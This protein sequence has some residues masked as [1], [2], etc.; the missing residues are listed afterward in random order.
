MGLEPIVIRGADVGGVAGLALGVLHVAA[1]FVFV[2]GN[3]Q[4]ATTL[5]FPVAYECA[6]GVDIAELLSGHPKVETALIAAAK[7][8]EQRGARA[9]VGACGSFANF[10][11]ALT[12]A[13][14]IPVFSSV[15]TQIP[16]LL[17]GL[18]KAQRLAVIFA[19]QH[20]FTA[21][22]RKECGILDDKR[23]VIVDCM[24]IS[25]FRALVEE[26]YQIR[27][28]ELRQAVTDLARQLLTVHPDI[29]MFM[30]QC[31][32]LPPYAAAIQAATGRP[33]VDV[34]TLANW[35]FS[36]VIRQS[37]AGYQ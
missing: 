8:L 9:I 29:G 7:R 25:A 26:P 1:P 4:N 19:D 14:S 35:T 32:E 10:Q 27:D 34:V 20:S 15:L 18:P 16:W 6:Q 11:S 33:V 13:V 28:G 12:A 30:L 3:I 23:L 17:Q 36:T 2:P 31:S 24:S 37:Y 22:V 5:R 21:R